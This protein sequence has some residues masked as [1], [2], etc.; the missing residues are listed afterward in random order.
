[1]NK[2]TFLEAWAN[3]SCRRGVMYRIGMWATEED[4]KDYIVGTLEQLLN[5]AR[6][7]EENE[8]ETKDNE[9]HQS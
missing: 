6:A 2:K 9:N 5:D 7:I 8:I 3:H 1:M 4:C